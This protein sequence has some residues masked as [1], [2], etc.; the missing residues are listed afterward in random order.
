MAGWEQKLEDTNEGTEQKPVADPPDLPGRAEAATPCGPGAGG[1]GAV[2]SGAGGAGASE[3]GT[4]AARSGGSATGRSGGSAT[5]RSGGSATGRSGTVGGRVLTASAGTSGGLETMEARAGVCSFAV[6]VA[7]VGI[8][9]TRGMAS[10]TNLAPLRARRVPTKGRAASTGSEGAGRCTALL[11]CIAMMPSPGQ[12]SGIAAAAAAATSPGQG[13]G[14]AAAAAAATS[15]GQG[16]GIAAAAAC[17][18]DLGSGTSG[19][20]ARSTRCQNTLSILHTS[21]SREAGESW[22][23]WLPASV[24]A[25]H[26]HGDWRTVG[27]RDSHFQAS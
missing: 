10:P 2:E 21:S 25:W 19:D 9:G 5:G 3:G 27:V 22:R 26:N 18:L 6:V 1:A 20:P 7:R 11:G 13:S 23:S 24:R 4:A 8:L 17:S 15:P 14:I 12:G 16:S